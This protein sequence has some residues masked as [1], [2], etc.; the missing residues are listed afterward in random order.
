[1][2]N[3]SINLIYESVMNVIREAA[4][5]NEKSLIETKKVIQDFVKDT[6]QAIQRISDRHEETEK[7]HK[8]TEKAIAETQKAIKE[9]EKQMRKLDNRFGKMT[10]QMGD[11]GNRFGEVM[12]H[13]VFPAIVSRFNELGYHFRIEFEGNFKVINRQRQLIAE[14]DAYL[15]ND[16]TIAVVEIKAKPDKEDV[17]D[18]IQRIERLKQNRQEFNEPSKIIIGAIAGAVFP[19]KLKLLPSKLVFMCLS[20]PAIL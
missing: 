2:S 17:K 6:N 8:E 14:I 10:K 4:I 20:N 5:E 9:T 13:M 19:E 1:M 15:E 7:Q 12:E 18:H 3:I 16:T 11:L